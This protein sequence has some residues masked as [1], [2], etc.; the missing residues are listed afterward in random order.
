MK[1]ISFFS[2]ALLL[3]TVSSFAQS[4]SYQALKDKFKDQSDV[5]SFSFSGWVGRL[6]LNM[7]GEHEFKEAIK[8]LSHVR[9]ITIPNSE[10][11]SQN[12]SVKGF[13]K[14]LRQDSFEELA[15]IHDKGEEVSIY[16]REG[17][18]HKNTYFVLVEEEQEVVAIELKGYL[19]PKL[20]NSKNTTLA[21]NK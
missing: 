8:D 10:F 21:I 19:D 16:L 4:T 6:V 13:K 15:F 12:V 7:A 9:I 2:V 3:T 17:N 18:N 20:L 5:H 1:S 14:V 11:S